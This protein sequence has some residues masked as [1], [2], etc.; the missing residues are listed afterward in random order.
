MR[1]FI[2]LLGLGSTV[3]GFYLM[4]TEGG[5]GGPSG[6]S[7]AFVI[8]GFITMIIFG[9]SDHASSSSRNRSSNELS[10]YMMRE[11]N[12]QFMEESMK[13]VTPESHG[14]YVPDPPQNNGFNSF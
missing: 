4:A 9:N 5:F 1:V 11:N 2:T 14:G 10:E 7:L 3:F 6:T 12:R 8:G 13:S